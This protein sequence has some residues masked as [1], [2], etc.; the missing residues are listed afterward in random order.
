MKWFNRLFFTRLA[1]FWVAF[2]MPVLTFWFGLQYFNSVKL[3][4]LKSQFVSTSE[5]IAGEA[6]DYY[7]NDIFWTS[8]LIETLKDCRNPKQ[9]KDKLTELFTSYRQTAGWVIVPSKSNP[10]FSRNMRKYMQRDWKKTAEIL[11]RCM[12]QGNQDLPIVDDYALR[13]FFGPHLQNKKIKDMKHV[14]K[15]GLLQTDFFQKHPLFWAIKV[16]KNLVIVLLPPRLERKTHGIQQFLKKYRNSHQLYLMTPAK[17]FAN[18]NE[19]DEKQLR[20]LKSKFLA[21]PLKVFNFNNKL[22]YGENLPDRRFLI[23]AIKTN[24]PGVGRLSLLF[25]VCL[26]FFYL[27]ICRSF[28]LSAIFRNIKI[29]T[30][31][32][33]FI[34]CS[35]IFPLLILVFFTGQY[36]D[37]KFQVLI[38]EKRNEAVK[39]VRLIE[40]KFSK[41]IEQMPISLKRVLSSQ[42]EALRKEGLSQEVARRIHSALLATN[43]DF[44]FI[45]SQTLPVLSRKGYLHKKG[46]NYFTRKEVSDGT[47]LKIIELSGKIGGSYLSFWNEEPVSQKALTEAELIADIVFH[48]P[49]D[50]SLHKIVEIHEQMGR[51]GFGSIGRPSFATVLSLKNKEK[52]DFVC[53]FQLGVPGGRTQFLQRIRPQLVSNAFGLKTVMIMRN[54]FSADSLKPFTD[55]TSIRTIFERLKDY[56]PIK[57][58]V[59]DIDGKS[60]IYAGCRSPAIENHDIVAFYPLENIKQKLA[61]EKEE[62][63]RLF[64]VNLIIVLL[65]AFLLSRTLLLPVQY[66]ENGTR[67]IDERNFAYRLP[68]LG[69]DEFGRMADVFND[70]ITDLQ[71]LSVA[72]VVQQSLF[73]SQKIDTG[74]FGLFGKSETLADL[75]GD[76]LD[77]FPVDESSFAVILGDVAG[78]GVGAAMIMAMAKSATINSKEFLNNPVEL[79]LRLH[80]LIYQTKTRKQKKIMTFQYL[81]VNKNDSKIRFCNAGGCNP[82]LVNGA[83]DKVEEIAL[84]AAALGA[85]KKGKFAEKEIEFA[86]GDVLVLY[87][88][89][90]VEAR[91]S[92]GEEIGYPRFREILLRCWTTDAEK[93]YQRVFGEYLDWLGSEPAQDDLSMVFL[94]LA[95]N[96]S[97]PELTN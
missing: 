49:I 72:R 13:K 10:L 41:E 6:F 82:F 15:F 38:D 73:P 78:H 11:N 46:F 96:D 26:A 8:Q 1:L 12:K 40:E 19:I 24:L 81:L 5:Q 71:E 62:L 30:T 56:P 70:A 84:P 7:N 53:I 77:Y 67:A 80:N 90:I 61:Q 95:E 35:N 58:E 79:T 2:A 89:G 66:L 59:T 44:N 22:L 75:G 32:F 93:F 21:S 3:E 39:F 36:L 65:I 47:S 16:E 85:F 69:E 18:S 37:Q 34:G 29:R 51:F 63:V 14:G 42:I 23:S 55:S 25:A 20:L 91:N 50:E 54:F 48:K 64:L 74:I 27:L 88:D 94:S 43:V 52:G 87:S 83:T 4:L 17:V 76:Y 33:A 60:W 57:A 68:D 97:V 86:L 45:A 31:I 9:V 92:A 28:E